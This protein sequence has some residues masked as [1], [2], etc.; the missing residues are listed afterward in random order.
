MTD[1]TLVQ[2]IV[3]TALLRGRFELR[4]GR[5]SNYYL[6]KYLFE[7]QPDIL[8][9]LGQRL[10]VHVAA[11]TNRVA[12]AELGGIPLVAATAMAA[13]RPAVLIR[14]QKK[15]Y[16]TSNLIE[17]TLETGDRIL[18][19]EDVA[20]SGGQVLEAA[21]TLQEAGGTVEKIVAVIDRQEGARENIEASGFPFASLL[22][23]S[24]LGI[25]AESEEDA[26]DTR[27][28]PGVAGGKPQ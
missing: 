14:N 5:I 25:P 20:T 27:P 13:N 7:T 19:V 24:D 1:E 9:E 2:R 16:G 23:R 26:A 17:G 4:S 3:E 10:A 21:R 11:S 15:G 22:T 12:G 18:I 8:A 6:D 28:R